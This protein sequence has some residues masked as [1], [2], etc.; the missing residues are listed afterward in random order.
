MAEARLRVEAAG[1]HVSLQD[2]GRFG[3]MRYG[4][5]A[6][7]PMD[8]FAHAAA[9]L[10]LGQPS[11][12]TAIEVSMGG[13]SLSCREGAVSIA[14][15]GGGFTLDHDG[16]RRDG[17]AVLR[18]EPGQTLAIRAGTWGSWCY[19]AVAGDLVC[20]RWLGRAATHA[21][22]GFGGGRLVAG[23]DVIVRDAWVTQDR[24]G[25]IPAP[26]PPT[27][28]LRLSAVAGPQEALFAPGALDRLTGE[29]FR[30]TS[31]FDRMGVRLDGPE[32]PLRDALSI[33][34]EPLLRG[35]VQVAGDGVA[36][37]L[38]ADHQTTGGYPKIATLL[39]TET[40]RLAQARPGDTLRI[41]L[42]DPEKAVALAR[43]ALAER[44]RS[45]DEIGKP[46]GSLAQRLVETNLI[47]G[48]T[49]GREA[50][51]EG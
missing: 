5:P 22:S 16:T 15:C 14:V 37:V 34:S 28:P 25:A 2:A 44:R 21:V 51:P 10:A 45:L 33:P 38:L 30:V 9:N 50:A 1:P 42:V 4:V 43:V 24:E 18:L 3:W 11:G 46:R 17:W 29:T 13:L 41:A 36:S 31:A 32:L 26:G 12:A 49:D 40:D 27:A 48:V 23:Q 6:S 20:E 8:R 7:G 35:A 39:S 47:S 19:V